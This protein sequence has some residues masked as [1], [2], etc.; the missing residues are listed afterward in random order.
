MKTRILTAAVGVPLLFILVL[1]APEIASALVLGVMANSNDPKKYK[2][3][4]EMC[5]NH[6]DIRVRTAAQRLLGKITEN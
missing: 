1:W 5:I 3:Y 2:D 4:A 6:S